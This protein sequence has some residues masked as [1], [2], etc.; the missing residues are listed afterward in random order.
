MTEQRKGRIRQRQKCLF[1]WAGKE[2]E[3]INKKNEKKRELPVVR[4]GATGLCT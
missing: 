1:M 3:K 4:P 2:N